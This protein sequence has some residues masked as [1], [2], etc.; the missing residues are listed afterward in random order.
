MSAERH[1]SMIE[2]VPPRVAADAYD[3]A[4]LGGGLAGLTLSI[5]IKRARPNTSVAVLEKR[6]G[7]APLAAFKVGESTVL[8]GATYFADVV[9]MRDHLDAAQ[10][11][12]NGL[13]FFPS[14]G[15]N[16]DITRRV[17]SGPPV[18][19]PVAT[20]QIDRGRFENELAA[21]ARVAGVD[22]LQGSRVGGV[23]L[24]A[25]RHTITFQ[26]FGT[27]TST[28]A[29]W[30][31]DAAGRASLL[32]RQLDL[33]EEVSHTINSSWFRLA[34]GLD[35][36][37]WGASDSAWMSRMSQP[38]LRTFSTNHLMG[39][40]YWIWLIP[41]SS[42]PISI[43][44]C[45]DPRYH[46]FEEINELGKLLDWLRRYEPQLAA[47]VAP[48]LGDVQDFLRVEDF[49]YGVKQT[50]SADRWALVGE[51]AAF[52]DPF[53]SPG[54]DMIAYSNTFACDLIT[55]DLD[56]EDVT[57]RVE[58]YNGLYQRTFRHVLSR[59]E[60]IYPAFGNPY[61]MAVKFSWDAYISHC[62]QVLCFINGKLTDLP[63]MKSVD[64]DIDRLY[65]LNI[66]LHALFREWAE[67]E[68][69]EYENEFCKTVFVTAIRENLAI[70]LQEFDDDGLRAALRKQVRDAEAM[71]VAIFFKAASALPDPPDESRPVNP[72]AISLR[73]ADWEAEGVHSDSGLTLDD[74]RAVAE[75][76]DWLFLDYVPAAT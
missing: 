19:P 2:M 74:A 29:R 27:E 58:F 20:W 1:A 32:K 21:R 52:A 71:A 25:D 12:K 8:S 57:E 50:S 73:P 17:E 10:L 35:F 33:A 34:G 47:A 43:G 31:V 9:G 66:N 41:L 54:S 68:P 3:V 61:V 36:E 38:G 37:E 26:Q 22:L 15:G 65:R 46:P 69:R 67:L 13:R 30:V 7:P 45:A 49:A 63:F 70:P 75:G 18:L 5:Q 62:A 44:I 42:G 55:R 6:E 40:G 39:E 4:I 76:V 64:D 16:E 14:A 59:T 51:A 60:D 72:Y 24:G 56:G 48:R 53:I 28:A 11:R 23:E